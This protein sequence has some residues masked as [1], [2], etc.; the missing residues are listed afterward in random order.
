MGMDYIDVKSRFDDS[1]KVRM[2]CS[3]A[4][5]SKRAE[6]TASKA[7]DSLASQ[8]VA[9]KNTLGVICAISGSNTMTMDDYIEVNRLIRVHVHEETRVLIGTLK[10][11]NLGDS[12]MVTILTTSADNEKAEQVFRLRA[13]QTARAAKIPFFIEDD[14]EIPQ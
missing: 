5:G 2:G 7:I 4:S 3:L 10:D 13:E 14:R 6:K 1:S 11:D 8:G 12:I 9:L